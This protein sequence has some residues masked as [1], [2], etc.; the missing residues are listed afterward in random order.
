MW[1]FMVEAGVITVISVG[2]AILLAHIAIP[3]VSL[4]TE[5][6]LA[7]HYGQPQFWI[8]IFAMVTLT[9][10]LSGTYPAFIL[11][12][13][14]PINTLKGKIAEHSGGI[15]FRKG[16]VIVQFILALLL[17]VGAL[18]I[19]EQVDFIK[20]KNLGI[21]KD[22]LM[23]LHHDEKIS[24]KMDA[25]R[26]ELLAQ[27][28]IV[29]VTSAGPSPIDIQASTSGVSW[30]GKRAEQENQ[31]LQKR[32]TDWQACQLFCAHFHSYFMPPIIGVGDFPGRTKD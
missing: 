5:K 4:I 21:N 14:R 24:A 29:K 22:N 27:E 30:P 6:S 13:F 31:E 12:S 3:H 20:N 10:L 19:Q 25:L 23:V 32:S 9:T 1:Q 2:V 7:I 16:L 17:I 11:S 18:V 26:N 28:A 8:G 15:S